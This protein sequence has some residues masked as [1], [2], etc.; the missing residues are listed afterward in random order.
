MF[1]GASPTLSA[2]EKVKIRVCAEL[3]KAL[4]CGNGARAFVCFSGGKP[5]LL[6]TKHIAQRQQG[7][8]PLRHA[9]SFGG[10]LGTLMCSAIC[11]SAVT[12]VGREAR[13]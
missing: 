6:L 13:V 8:R 2:C 7:C 12:G 10:K 9:A 3:P 1:S 4:S 5:Y 11:V